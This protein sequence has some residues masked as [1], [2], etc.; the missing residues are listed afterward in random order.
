M[1]RRGFVGGKCTCDNGTIFYLFLT[2]FVEYLL[3]FP[4]CPSSAGQFL[5]RVCCMNISGYSLC[6][7]FPMEIL[8]FTRFYLEC[9]ES[10]ANRQQKGLLILSR[11]YVTQRSTFIKLHISKHCHYLLTIKLNKHCEI[12]VSCSDKERNCIQAHETACNLM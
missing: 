10:I 1:S 9:D 3:F 4:L 7:N 8:L 5:I 11:R 2:Y 12:L 6:S